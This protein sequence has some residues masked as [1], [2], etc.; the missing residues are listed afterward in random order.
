MKIKWVVK[1]GM[2]Q[3]WSKIGEQKIVLFNF[4]LNLNDKPKLKQPGLLRD[5]NGSIT[6]GI[7]QIFHRSTENMK[8]IYENESSENIKVGEPISRGD[9]WWP[10][11]Q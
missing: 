4:H 1:T 5:E 8:D 9:F 11:T 10:A 6:I 7:K 2:G 3:Q